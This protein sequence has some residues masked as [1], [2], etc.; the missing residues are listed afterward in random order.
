MATE[1][2]QIQ[3]E[4]D[5]NSIHLQVGAKVEV[6]YLNKWCPG[7]ILELC[8]NDKIKIKYDIKYDGYGKGEQIK[9][10]KR[11]MIGQEFRLKIKSQDDPNNEPNE[12]PLL[13]GKEFTLSLIH[14]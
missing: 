10:F 14:I 4:K 3:L 13:N 2:K 8:Y 7:T 9:H 6:Y 5:E 12:E 1:S 11:S